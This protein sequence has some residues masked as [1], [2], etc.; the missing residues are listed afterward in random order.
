MHPQES[1]FI[2]DINLGAISRLETISVPNLGENTRGLE[3]VCKVSCF[4][5]LDLLQLTGLIDRGDIRSSDIY[6]PQDMRSPRFAY[7]TDSSQPDI[8]EVLSKHA[9]PLCHNLVSL[10]RII[11]YSVI[12]HVVCFHFYEYPCLIIKIIPGL[13]AVFFLQPPFAFLYKEQ[14]PVDGW[15]V[16]DPTSE[17]KRQVR[18]RKLCLQEIALVVYQ[19][20]LPIQEGEPLLRTAF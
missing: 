3:L 16:Y 9:F 18:A 6:L 20:F 11:C 15:K 10:I 1:Q 2:L 8:I 14:F 12:H 4:L 17:Y 19:G 5:D 7:K 13:K